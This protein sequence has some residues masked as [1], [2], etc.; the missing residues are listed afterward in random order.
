MGIATKQNGRVVTI[1]LDGEQFKILERVA[2]ALNTLSWEGQENDNTPESVCREWVG[3]MI[4]DDFDPP[5][6]FVG[7]IVDSID[8]RN[9]GDEELDKTRREEVRRAFVDA[10]LL[11][12]MK[13]VNVAAMP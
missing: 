9:G 6:Q 2:D 8:T 13:P 1:T 4:H 7:G 11:E 3:W 5:S 12:R 10:G